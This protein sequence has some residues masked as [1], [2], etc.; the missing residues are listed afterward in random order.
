MN[1]S[2]LKALM[3][4]VC[5]LVFALFSEIKSLDTASDKDKDTISR[6]I[7]VSSDS[8][9]NLLLVQEIMKEK[10]KSYPQI[11]RIRIVS[12]SIIIGTNSTNIY[13]GILNGTRGDSPPDQCIKNYLLWCKKR[14]IPSE[15]EL[16]SSECAADDLTDSS[17]S[18]E[19][20]SGDHVWRDINFTK[21]ELD[22]VKEQKIKIWYEKNSNYR[23]DVNNAKDLE[24]IKEKMVS[25][26]FKKE[27]TLEDLTKRVSE[28]LGTALL[29]SHVRAILSFQQ[30]DAHERFV[31][32][33]GRADKEKK[34]TK[35]ELEN[36]APCIWKG[37]SMLILNPEINKD[38]LINK[39]E[40]LYIHNIW[41]NI[42]KHDHIFYTDSVEGEDLLKELS[43]K[44]E[45]QHLPLVRS[46]TKSMGL[47]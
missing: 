29:L 16:S 4:A 33:I 21:E 24:E 26:M 22:A 13:R 12:P 42:A 37:G 17:I 19:S 28:K 40:M 25:L 39:L 6:N 34:F 36:F 30:I 15:D 31:K 46:K 1:A 27:L 23:W 18:G 44:F 2:K 11:E 8:S 10:L 9:K 7:S 32:V 3:M 41:G 43:G 38:E 35:K 20:D 14:S 45:L 47:S 5:C